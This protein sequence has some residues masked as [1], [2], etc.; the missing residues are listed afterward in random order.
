MTVSIRGM[1]PDDWQA[2][3]EV[4]LKA[5]N[6][7]YQQTNRPV[8]TGQR[9]KLNITA[10]FAMYPAGCFVAVDQNVI[11]YVF[12]RHWGKQ[13]WIGV[14]GID[15][16]YHGQ[17]I[18]KRLIQR[19]LNQLKK[20]GCE[21]IGLETMPDSPYNVGLYMSMG[22]LPVYNTLYM[23]KDLMGDKPPN[24]T[25]RLSQINLKDGLSSIS[26]LSRAAH[27]A[28]DYAQEAKNALDFGWGDVLLPGW[29]HPWGFAIVRFK[30]VRGA[31]QQ[32]VC[33]LISIV[34][35][36][37]GRN[38]FV[39]MVNLV[40]QFALQIGAAQITLPIYAREHQALQQTVDQGYRVSR[41][42]VRMVVPQPYP[43]TPGLDLNRWTM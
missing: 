19:T 23:A 26:A 34:L 42:N 1:T 11:G 36:A 17:G 40:E 25:P 15:P 29:P 35:P 28:V 9:T 43:D 22:M 5:F 30:P 10:S 3:S 20:S 33:D 14:F 24:A 2:V 21:T 27:P 4:D 31:S 6:G 37:E 7:Y 12:S 16:Q 13:G 39:A 8:L 18:G 38:R 32:A 41:I